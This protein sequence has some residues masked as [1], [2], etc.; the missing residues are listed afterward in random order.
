MSHREAI[1]QFAFFGQDVGLF[2]IMCKKKGARTNRKTIKH[3]RREENA[4]TRVVD[5][6]CRELSF[7]E[8]QY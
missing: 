1:F 4:F 7:G 6:I 5:G 3:F 8:L 2:A